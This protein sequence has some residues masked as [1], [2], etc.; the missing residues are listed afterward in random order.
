M[1][2]VSVTVQGVDQFVRKYTQLQRTEILY[3]PMVRGVERLKSFMAKYPNQRNPDSKYRRTG[4]LGRRWTT[5]V[6]RS[7]VGLTGKVGNNT[8]YAPWVQ[9]ERFQAEIHQG[10]WQTD[11]DAIRGN[12]SAIVRDFESVIQNAIR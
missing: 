6:T 8:I 4:T 11:R 7:A 5:R 1:A 10:W 9:S 12:R 2:N 3:P